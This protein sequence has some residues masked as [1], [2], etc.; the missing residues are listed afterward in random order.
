MKTPVLIYDAQCRFCEGGISWI[1][2]RARPGEIE[3]LPS[4]SPE[5]KRRY[6][7]LTDE[8]CQEGMLLFLPDG[9]IQRG[10]QGLPE[11]LRRLR[12]WRWLALVF[13]LPIAGFL[14]RKVYSW[15]ARNR[16]AISR[17]LYSPKASRASDQ[18]EK[19]R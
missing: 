7:D 13:R 2:Q 8:D 11:I 14:S 1:T 6:P 3:F 15:A 5:R 19:G 12:G 16:Y 9:S 4:Q 10:D 17:C 18:L